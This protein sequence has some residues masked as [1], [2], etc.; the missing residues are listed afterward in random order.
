MNTYIII[1]AYNEQKHIG[2]VV[3]KIR[4]QGF[5]KIIVID[6]GSDDKGACAAEAE[7]AGATV[8][9]HIINMGKGCALRTGC[10]Y[11]SRQGATHLVFIDADGQHD[12]KEIPR[13]LDA[14]KKTDIVFGSRK[15]DTRMPAVM[16]FGNNFINTVVLLIY[17]L[18]L[19]DT[20]SGFRA[21]TAEAYRKVRWKANDYS[22]ESEMI[23]NASKHDLKYREITIENIYP[24]KYKGTTIFDGVKIVFSMIWWKI[25]RW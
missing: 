5:S 19:K 2:S 17:G 14:L 21:M 15:Y 1:P 10:D 24:E 8:L 7:K 12:P 20:Q 9:R 22:V 18:K 11:A 6:D 16:R 23:A 3:K 4:E 25:N 13:F